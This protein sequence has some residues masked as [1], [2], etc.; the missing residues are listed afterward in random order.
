MFYGERYQETCK[1]QLTFSLMVVILLSLLTDFLRPALAI[2]PSHDTSTGPSTPS[3]GATLKD[4]IQEGF[5]WMAVPK[6]RRT[7]YKRRMRKNGESKILKWA[8]P[9]KNL[10][11]C[12][13][14][15][16]WNEAHLICG[17]LCGMIL[18]LFVVRYVV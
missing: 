12:L 15:G 13:Q 9:R 7:I 2:V 8:T 10:V 14:C 3:A 6:R 5:L 16:H 4:I 17:K 1:F 11:S 18:T